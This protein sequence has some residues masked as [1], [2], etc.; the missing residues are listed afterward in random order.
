MTQGL[1]RKR[2][3]EAVLERLEIRI[4]LSGDFE[5]FRDPRVVRHV[6]IVQLQEHGRVVY[7]HEGQ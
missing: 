5:Q 7:L 6:E 3:V 2:R 1:F 4:S